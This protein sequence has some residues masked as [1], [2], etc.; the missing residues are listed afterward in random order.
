MLFGEEFARLEVA[1]GLQG[2]L[3]S[4]R[5]VAQGTAG[6]TASNIHVPLHVRKQIASVPKL[7]P[8]SFSISGM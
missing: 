8:N 5:E 6:R 7:L 1:R 4:A 2:K 3:S